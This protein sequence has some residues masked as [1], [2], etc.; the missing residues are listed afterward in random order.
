[1]S[2][3]LEPHCAVSRRMVLHVL[4]ATSLAVVLIIQGSILNFYI[5]SYYKTNVSGYFWFIGDFTALF[6]FAAALTISY[7]YISYLESND[8]GSSF[9][10][11]PKI[12]CTY[13]PS[14]K[15]GI[16]P[17]SYVSWLLYSGLMVAKVIVIFK[18]D[19]PDDLKT[20]ELFGPKLLQIAIAAS[21]VIFLL[22]AEG[23]SPAKRHT[24]QHAYVT[25]TCTKTGIEI[26]DSVDLLQLLLVNETL[27]VLTFEL[28]NA[29][30]FLCS[31]TFLF[32]ALALYRLSLSDEVAERTAVPLK[33]VYD[34]CHLLFLDVPFLVLRIY[35]W[36]YYHKDASVF[37]VKNTFGIIGAL[38]SLCPDIGEIIQRTRKTAQTAG[39]GGN[40]YLQSPTGEPEAVEMR[41]LTRPL[42]HG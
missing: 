26:L 6:I 12:M 32:P 17:L 15:L 8:R 24:L 9:S 10:L 14:S 5:I 41:E 42:E 20:T 21:G 35:I 4:D 2:S 25:S 18:S 29:V 40:G 38:R 31:F 39:G 30:L 37:V 22:L 16:L 7:Q 23:H 13:Y 28:E 34:I 36:Y 3:D 33:V 27:M 19:I 1:M 11:T